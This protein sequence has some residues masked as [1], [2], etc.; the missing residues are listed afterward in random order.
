MNISW[1]VEFISQHRLLFAGGV[2]A[3]I[4]LIYFIFKIFSPDDEEDE[5]DDE[6]EVD[7][8]TDDDSHFEDFEPFAELFREMNL[9]A[10]RDGL[11]IFNE[12]EEVKKFVGMAKL[13]PSNPVLQTADMRNGTIAAQARMFSII[14]SEGQLVSI[15]LKKDQSE[16]YDGIDEQIKRSFEREDFSVSEEKR[17]RNHT[18]ADQARELLEQFKSY[19]QENEN[20]ESEV[21]I[22][23]ADYIT[24]EDMDETNEVERAKNMTRRA[25]EDLGIQFQQ[26][27]QAESAVGRDVEPLDDIGIL[28]VLY[29]YFNREQSIEVPF[30]ELIKTENY[31]S[32]TTGSLDEEVAINIQKF[33]NDFVYAQNSAEKQRRQREQA[34]AKK[35][36]SEK[37]NQ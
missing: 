2:L 11:M 33:M 26:M 8:I 25:K 28:E 1:I 29:R 34:A 24:D 18:N 9:V 35:K 4:V 6:P 14:Q 20:F 19:D 37:E 36:I 32:M 17:A 7:P 16:Y 10:I 12:S 27:S 30:R 31:A 5:E 23:L 15:P 13:M 22:L 21:Y 3:L